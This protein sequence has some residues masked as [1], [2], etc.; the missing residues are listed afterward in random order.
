MCIEIAK[1]LTCKAQDDT[2]DKKTDK[3][4]EK[5][6]EYTMNMKEIMECRSFA[7][8]GDTENS[9]KY[10][11]RIAEGLRENGYKVYC[12]GKEL[13]SFNDIE[14]DI[15]IIDLCIHPAKGLPLIKECRKDFR[16]IV[17]QPGASDEALIEYLDENHIPYVDGCLLVGLSVYAEKRKENE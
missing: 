1:G 4:P 16:C 6:S 13:A 12:V 7:V 2:I 8:A 10:A 15:D 17:I 11:Y 5:R 9:E 14:D 3:I